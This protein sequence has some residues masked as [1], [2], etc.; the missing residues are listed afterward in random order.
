MYPTLSTKETA[1]TTRL[2][3][4]LITWS[5]GQHCLLDIAEKCDSAVW[6]LYPIL[7]TLVAHE[8]ISLY[9]EAVIS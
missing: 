5:D 4:N 6:N 3:M 2:M 1:E 7:E 9:Q 8:L